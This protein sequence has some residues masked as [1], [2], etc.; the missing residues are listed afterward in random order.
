MSVCLSVSF[1]SI[2]AKSIPGIAQK[3]NRRIGTYL[4]VGRQFANKHVVKVQCA[5]TRGKEIADIALHEGCCVLSAKV[6]QCQNIK[7]K[8]MF[9]FYISSS[10]R[11]CKYASH[12]LQYRDSLIST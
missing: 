12:L 7:T 6:G 3:R 1:S 5:Q 2:E 9:L 4:Y 8:R 11:I 10:T